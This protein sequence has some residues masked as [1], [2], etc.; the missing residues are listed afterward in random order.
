MQEIETSFVTTPWTMGVL[1][2][3]WG[4]SEVNY[5]LACK[6][7]KLGGQEKMK[8]FEFFWVSSWA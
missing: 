2:Y 1:Q 5:F 6:A 7:F 8:V 4:I 3:L